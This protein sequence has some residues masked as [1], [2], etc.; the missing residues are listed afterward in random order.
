MRFDTRYRTSNFSSNLPA[1]VKWLLIANV[2]TFLLYYLIPPLA[3]HMTLLRLAPAAV[4][5]HFAIFQLVTY[6]F[7]HADPWH[8]LMN[9][10]GLWMF[11]SPLE[12]D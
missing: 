8:I 6:L 1:G 3:E 7:L 5:K 10:L 11:G 9:M 2:G 4:L 12:R